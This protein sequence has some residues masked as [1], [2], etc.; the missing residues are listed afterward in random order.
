MAAF[1]RCCNMFRSADSIVGF[2]KAWVLKF[3]LISFKVSLH[4]HGTYHTRER[5]ILEHYS[6][7]H[8]EAFG[9]SILARTYWCRGSTTIS[10]R[11]SKLCHNAKCCWEVSED[12][13]WVVIKISPVQV[14]QLLL[15][16]TLVFFIHLS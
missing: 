15:K 9:G 6:F 14:G 8:K 7:E 12:G 2:S 1:I 11:A 10:Q 4:H 3:L 5:F 13:Y 16:T